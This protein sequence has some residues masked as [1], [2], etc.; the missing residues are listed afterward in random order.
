MAIEYD[1]VQSI[2]VGKG[3]IGFEPNGRIVASGL[4]E[5]DIFDPLAQAIG[6]I[7]N[8]SEFFQK[9][10]QAE[11][12]DVSVIGFHDGCNDQG[13][14]IE[15]QGILA[16]FYLGDDEFEVRMTFAEF[17]PILDAWQKAWA[18]AQAYKYTIKA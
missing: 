8:P 17:R 6:Q 16:S 15:K 12:G 18:A 14:E 10:E 5:V 4:S 9:I 3:K 7:A 2:A 11:S 1:F 13:I